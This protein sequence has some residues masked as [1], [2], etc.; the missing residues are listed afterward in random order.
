M[1]STLHTINAGQTVNR[2][3]GMFS[4]EEEPQLRQRIGETLRY[5]V[6]QLVSKVGG[7][8]LMLSEINGQQPA[9]AGD[10]PLRRER[11]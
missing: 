4:R 1:F 11:G 2:I 10:N 8:R 5:V 6:S 9:H 7:G 3:L